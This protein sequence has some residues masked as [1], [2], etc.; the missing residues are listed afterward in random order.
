MPDEILR[1]VAPLP[2]Y[3][4]VIDHFGSSTDNQ[5][6]PSGYKLTSTKDNEVKRDLFD[7][8]RLVE[9]FI[10]LDDSYAGLLSQVGKAVKTIWLNRDQELAPELWPIHDVDI[11]SID[12]LSEL[13]SKLH[14]PSL[15]QCETWWDEWNLPENIRTHVKLVA[16]TAYTLAVLLRR[17]GVG[18]D[19]ILT[20]RGSLMHDL[21][22]IETLNQV[23]GHGEM[24][25]DF[26]DRQ[27]YPQLAE[28]VRGHLMHKIYETDAVE[29]SWETTLV[30]FCDKLVEGDRLV[31]FDYR[32]DQ[33]KIRYPYYREAM[34][35]AETHVWALSDDICAI[36]SLPTHNRLIAML[37]N[38]ING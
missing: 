15:V 37:N 11:T 20:H 4:K 29:Q 10:Y 3:R 25:G 31:S 6:L 2:I 24:G 8:T 30:N 19:P 28:I 21:D 17:E 27:G 32:L 7:G 35:K 23:M 33:L 26:F 5:N 13:E 1:L 38:L 14:N 36:L 16:K 34:E 12:E 22:K 18:V 9:P